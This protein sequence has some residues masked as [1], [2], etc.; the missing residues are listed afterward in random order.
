MNV[1]IILIIIHAPE[2]SN[3][4]I[5]IGMINMVNVVKQK[6]VKNYQLN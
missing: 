2:I 1:R 4:N 5:V 3:K 6:L